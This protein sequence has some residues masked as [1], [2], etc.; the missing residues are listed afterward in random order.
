MRPAATAPT[1]AR[2]DAR[3]AIR[4]M[5]VD[6]S[7]TV[8]T[9]FSRMIESEPDLEVVTTAGSAEVALAKLST[10]SVDVILLDLEMPGIGGLGALPK[11]LERGN[12][13]QVL[14]VSSLT[15]DGAEHSLAALSM[16]AADT[17]A[18]P[19]L[20]GFD[21]SYRSALL[22]RIRAL[23]ESSEA[24]VPQQARRAAPPVPAP[25][26]HRKPVQALAI[27][28]STGGIHALNR[29]LA[30][31]PRDFAPPIL[32]TQHLPDS[33]MPVFARQLEVASAR[34]AIVAGEPTEIRSGHIYVAPGH[35]HLTVH[36]KAGRLVTGLSHEPATSGC[37]PSVDPM[38]ASLARATDGEA[39]AVLLSGMGRDGLEGATDLEAAGGTILAQDQATSSVWGMPGAVTRAGLATT[40]GPPEELAEAL[41]AMKTVPAWT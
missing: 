20:G 29:M 6:D 41:A 18:K 3:R 11:L 12:G 35:G 8:R 36:R 9:A 31:L 4:V 40:V 37:M 23:G 5:V 10:L 16:G 39:V 34:K 19:R 7:V 2:A 22:A 17:M 28:A 15:A 27:G 25:R 24:N 32:V 1:R 30:A 26:A 13:V 14:V 38:L 21:E 33:F